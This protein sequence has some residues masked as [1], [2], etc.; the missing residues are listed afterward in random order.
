[1]SIRAQQVT[2][3]APVLEALITM[4]TRAPAVADPAQTVVELA[5]LEQA[6]AATRRDDRG[7]GTTWCS[8]CRRY[9]THTA[10]DCPRD[11]ALHA[12]AR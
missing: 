7:P 8:T 5:A 9:T 3:D 11:A 1:M 10:A 2:L 4:A 12:E 6:R